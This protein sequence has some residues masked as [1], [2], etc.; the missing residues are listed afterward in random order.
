MSPETTDIVKSAAGTIDK[1]LLHKQGE[2]GIVSTGY[3]HDEPLLGYLESKEAL[4]YLFDN[5]KKGITVTRES[6][7][8]VIT[9]DSNYRTIL[10]VTSR[11][12]LC[13]VGR[14]DGDTVI[15]IPLEDITETAVKTGFRKYL[16][17]IHSDSRRYDFYTRS[18][19]E[20]EAAADYINRHRRVA[21]AEPPRDRENGSGA[22]TENDGS[23][24]ESLSTETN[25]SADNGTPQRHKRSADSRTTDESQSTAEA[26]PSSSA[27]RTPFAD[28]LTQ[29][30]AADSTVEAVRE[31]ESNA[32]RA[33]TEIDDADEARQLL[34]RAHNS[35]CQ[36]LATDE[37]GIDRNSLEERIAEIEQKLDSLQTTGSHHENEGTAEP[38]DTDTS[39]AGLSRKPDTGEAS[40][41]RAKMID[42][43]EEA[44]DEL[45]RI[46]KYGDMHE[47]GP[48]EAMEY[49][50]QFENWQAALESTDIDIEGRLVDDLQSVA[51]Q[52]GRPPIQSELDDHGTHSPN[53]NVEYFGSYDQA[54]SAAGLEK[55]SRDTLRAELR[56]LETKLGCPP[57][58]AHVKEHGEYP[59]S[60]YR[61]QF[62]SVRMAAEEAGMDYESAVVDAVKALAVGLGHRPK[63]KEFDEYAMYSSSYIYNYFDGWLATCKA[64][65]VD[66]DDAVEELRTTLSQSEID[67]LL[68]TAAVTETFYE[69]H[70]NSGTVREDTKE[71]T[72]EAQREKQRRE[73]LRETLEAAIGELGRLP[74]HNEMYDHEEIDPQEYSHVFGSWD[75]ALQAT[76]IDVEARL[77]EALQEVGADIGRTPTKAEVDDHGTYDSAWYSEYFDSWKDAIREAGLSYPTERDLLTELHQLEGE[78]GYVPARQH[79]EE[80]GTYPPQFYRRQFGSVKQATAAA[81]MDYEDDVIEA[82]QDIAVD[83][84][85]KPKAKEFSE[86]AQYSN[87]YVYD[88]FD[89]WNDA[90]VAAGVSSPKAIQ[91]LRRE[92]VEDPGDTSSDP[93]PADRL[94]PSP[95]AEYYELFGNLVAV[96]EALLGEDMDESLGESALMTRWHG[97]VRD[98]WAGEPPTA[99]S[100]SYGA[101]QNERADV[102]ITEYRETYGDGEGVTDF[103]AVETAFLSEAIV[104]L[105]SYL[106]GMERTEAAEIQIPKAPESDEPLPVIVESRTEYRQAKSLC[107]EFP[108]EPET[109][110]GQQ[111]RPTS[112]GSAEESPDSDGD[113]KQGA[114]AEDAPDEADGELTD[115]GGV[116]PS[117]AKSLRRAGYTTKDD[118]KAADKEELAEIEEVGSHTANRIKLL[119]G[120]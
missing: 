75:N 31:A 117:V 14:Q 104:A 85:R 43:I 34:I 27:A 51:A 40:S 24:S 101:Q 15:D 81:G 45:D 3:L 59:V 113:G 120:S 56:R 39:T 16:L 109:G 57:T 42:A 33:D 110:S 7:D 41:R 63:S 35:L 53:R 118:L 54:L 17:R 19:P 77:L 29:E 2:G 91:D 64:A 21:N 92:R 44:A 13:V 99:F 66:S 108:E 20:L 30:R 84:G 60:Y 111:V 18:D 46:P 4:E 36:V 78:L 25:Q 71:D 23:G 50:K 67:E 87:S 26:K 100:E 116:T 11:R 82:I 55:P 119:V 103:Q 62:E 72:P 115:I 90:C 5:R 89:S 61:K 48:F 37:S 10:A 9:P 1:D 98:R 83:L 93:G 94:T 68:E 107:E 106:T 76:D 95:L 47:T 96:Q 88:Y 105:L 12:V 73:S 8:R 74:S 70:S 80:H 79:V 32:S 65:G 28:Y 58:S 6:E 49:S 52:L 86:H 112:T 114:Q 97:L 22:D 38:T 69:T 102:T